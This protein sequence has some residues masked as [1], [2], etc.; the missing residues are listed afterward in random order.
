MVSIPGV[1]RSSG[2][3]SGTSCALVFRFFSGAG[4]SGPSRSG[5]RK[6]ERAFS[7][8]S[9]GAREPDQAHSSRGR[10]LLPVTSPAPPSKKRDAQSLLQLHAWL[11][12]SNADPPEDTPPMSRSFALSVCL[13]L[14]AKA[15]ASIV[16]A[17]LHLQTPSQLSHPGAPQLDVGLQQQAPRGP[18]RAQKS[19]RSRE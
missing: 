19:S 16:S 18:A 8:P 9:A 17:L 4:G 10:R 15:M 14:R 3:D 11:R 12:H 13:E 6:T 1:S 5:L 2:V 7:E